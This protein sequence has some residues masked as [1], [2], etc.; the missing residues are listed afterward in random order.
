[1]QKTDGKQ[2]PPK[3]IVPLDMY[4]ASDPAKVDAYLEKYKALAKQ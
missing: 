3:I 2:L 1:V 4:Y